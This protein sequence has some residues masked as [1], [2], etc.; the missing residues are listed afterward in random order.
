MALVN[1]KKLVI[2]TLVLALA[3]LG[4]NHLKA[5]AEITTT[6]CHMTK[7]GLKS[8]LPYV[9]REP[10]QA[11]PSATCCSAIATADI[12]CLCYFKG[13]ALLSF[14][15]V[16]PELAMQLPAKCNL[17]QSVHCPNN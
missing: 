2:V 12:P 8:C 6:F 7:D 14:Y 17:G 1:S 11:A 10:S 13:S 4:S 16:D 9:S 3:M 15:G 5:S